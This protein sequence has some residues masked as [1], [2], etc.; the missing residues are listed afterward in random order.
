MMIILGIVGVLAVVAG[1]FY[2]WLRVQW[3][4]DDKDAADNEWRCLHCA[5]SVPPPAP[6]ARRVKVP[7]RAA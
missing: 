5:R 2:L 7:V 1:G 6:E 3:A 4:K